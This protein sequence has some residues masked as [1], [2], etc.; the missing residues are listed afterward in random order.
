MD[1]DWDDSC[2]AV[3]VPPPPLQNHDSVDEGHSLSRGRG[4]P[5]FNEDDEKENGYGERRGR[6][7]TATFKGNKYGGSD[8]RNFNNA[9]TA[10]VDQGQEPEEEW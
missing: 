6:G 2:E 4:F 1:D 7:G 5:S 8:V 10:V 9:N 3:V